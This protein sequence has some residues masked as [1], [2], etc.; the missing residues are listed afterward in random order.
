MA[1][2][3]ASN[4]CSIS[5]PAGC[6]AL[7]NHN[8]GACSKGCSDSFDE[9][10]NDTDRYSIEVN[11]FPA[12]ELMRAFGGDVASLAD[13][14]RKRTISFKLS[15]VRAAEITKRAREAMR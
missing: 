2:C 4:G 5:C 6:Y 14:D 1:D 7:Y 11:D 15:D 10:M 3:D 9:E 13:D 12:G 8:T